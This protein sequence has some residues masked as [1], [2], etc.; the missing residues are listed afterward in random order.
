ME[1]KRLYTSG[2]L[3]RS[4]AAEAGTKAI[5]TLGCGT[6]AVAESCGLAGDFAKSLSG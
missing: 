2:G 6:L 5:N 3:S 1:G 4:T